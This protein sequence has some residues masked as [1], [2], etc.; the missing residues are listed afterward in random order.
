MLR[1]EHQ[2]ILERTV[3][4][5]KLLATEID[6]A[7]VPRI[8]TVLDSLVR[9]L[10][11]HTAKEKGILFP[12]LQV[13]LGFEDRTIPVMLA[14]HAEVSSLMASLVDGLM[15]A[16][17]GSDTRIF[18]AVSERGRGLVRLL[19]QHISKEDNVLFWIAALQLSEAEKT[20]ITLKMRALDPPQGPEYLEPDLDK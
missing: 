7:L 5:E 3:R 18:Q 19:R 11:T 14:E 2:R 4:L 16:R 17:E 8:H 9:L 6:R 13:H 1:E 10:E 20:E 12:A 15:T